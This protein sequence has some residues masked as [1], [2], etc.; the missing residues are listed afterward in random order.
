MILRS[1]VLT[2]LLVATTNAPQAGEL[3]DHEWKIVNY[4]SKSCAPCRVEIP[5]FNHLSQALASFD[6]AVLGVNFDEDERDKTLQIAEYMGIEFPTLTI[7]E[8]ETLNLA[9]PSVLPTTYILAPDNT[10]KAK[11]IGAQD[12]QSI[13]SKLAEFGIGKQNLETPSAVK[14]GIGR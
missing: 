2:I 1:L 8:V 4:W 12:Q 14:P 3:N 7:K 9:P 13:L 5:E 11:L 10:V 6:V